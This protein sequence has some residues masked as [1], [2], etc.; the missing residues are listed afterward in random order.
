MF[1]YIGEIRPIFTSIILYAWLPHL[2]ESCCYVAILIMRALRPRFHATSGFFL[3]RLLLALD[4]DL[5]K[6]LLPLWN[7]DNI[8]TMTSLYCLTY[9]K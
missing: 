6:P 8:T 9:N 7:C 2:Q 4:E 1:W 5:F 3:I